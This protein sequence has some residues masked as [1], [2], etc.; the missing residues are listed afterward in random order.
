MEVNNLAHFVN[1]KKWILMFLMMAMAHSAFSQVL[2]DQKRNGRRLVSTHAA[3]LTDE[4]KSPLVY[5]GYS[6]QIEGGSHAYYLTVGIKS[7][8]PISKVNAGDRLL[9]KIG[10]HDVLKYTAQA[11]SKFSQS[12]QTYYSNSS[13]RINK[14]DIDRIARAQRLRIAMSDGVLDVDVARNAYR[15]TLRQANEIL[16][17]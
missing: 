12:G 10:N 14:S 7:N 3:V 2:L 16:K 13:Y 17:F 9:L 4:G 11:N 8:Q 6:V 15:N 5:I 1:M